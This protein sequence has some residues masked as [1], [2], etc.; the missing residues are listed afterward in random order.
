MEDHSTQ[1][2]NR[3]I[4]T[5]KKI[6]T[7]ELCTYDATDHWS[8][9]QEE[10]LFVL[11]EHV[12]TDHPIPTAELVEGY[13][14]WMAWDT[15]MDWW[16]DYREMLAYHEQVY[17]SKKDVR[18]FLSTFIGEAGGLV[19]HELGMVKFMALTGPQMLQ[20]TERIAVQVG[21]MDKDRRPDELPRGCDI[22]YF[23]SN[24]LVGI[25]WA[26]FRQRLGEQ[27]EQY[28]LTD[29][30]LVRLLWRACKPHPKIEQH[31]RETLGPGTSCARWNPTG[32]WPT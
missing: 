18:N 4:P 27:K 31:I 30:E 2:K 21:A 16:A 14:T 1:L 23:K 12:R 10:L 20:V 22:P 24:E 8:G 17:G 13:V 32:S 6:C 26:R 29:R 7:F 9:T 15:L 19:M 25:K 3:R 11:E 28:D 5:N